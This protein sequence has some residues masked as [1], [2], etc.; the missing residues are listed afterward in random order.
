MGD[1]WQAQSISGAGRVRALAGFGAFGLAWGGWGAAL[2]GV[3]EAAGVDDGELGLALL[4]I[5]V[6]ALGSMRLAGSVLDR[7]GPW[8]T[9]ATLVLLAAALALAGLAQS[10]ATLCLALLV[11]GAASGAADVAINAEAVASESA[12]GRPLLSLAHGA[13]SAAVI[14]G[15]LLAGLL[16]QAEP[17][18]GFA[19]AVVATLVAALAVLV[20]RAPPA[21]GVAT[22]PGRR[23]LRRLPRPLLILGGICALCFFVENA[24]QSWGAVHLEDDLGASPASAALAPALFAASAA[25]SRIVVHGLSERLGAQALIRA[26]ALLGAAGTLL[27]ALAEAQLPALVG[28]VIAGGGISVCA[29]ILI[30]LAGAGTTVA[31]RA[32]AVSVVTT[33]A[34]LGFV[35]GPPVT[36]LLAQ[37]TTLP[38]ALGL[39]SVVSLAVFV[40]AA[41]ARPTEPG[42]LKSEPS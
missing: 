1:A 13:F 32:A 2:P 20:A 36:G 4:A 17:G 27:G 5:G 23:R 10:F 28:I 11:L 8:V 24:W 12:T 31:I 9:P 38:T 41:L 22:V 39:V 18:P 34:Y 16:R 7:S 6:G 33:T 15:S 26:G 21:S 3:Q 30:S 29:P 42:S 40:L 37:A 14:L 25:L 19:L 35:V